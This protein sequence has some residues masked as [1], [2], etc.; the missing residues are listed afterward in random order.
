MIL[1]RWRSAEPGANDHPRLLKQIN[2]VEC[3]EIEEGFLGAI[4]RCVEEGLHLHVEVDE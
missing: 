2:L 1:S 3:F 4:K